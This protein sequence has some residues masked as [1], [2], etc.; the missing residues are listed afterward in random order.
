[1]FHAHLLRLFSLGNKLKNNMFRTGEVREEKSKSKMEVKS[2][3]IIYIN[4]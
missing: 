4:N 2:P 1:M 3:I